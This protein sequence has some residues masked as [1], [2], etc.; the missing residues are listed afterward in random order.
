MCHQQD[1]YMRE[2]ERI[3]AAAELGPV[4]HDNP[5]L[6]PSFFAKALDG[7]LLDSFGDEWLRAACPEER[8]AE[9]QALRAL[10]ELD[11]RFRDPDSPFARY[12]EAMFE[13]ALALYTA[14]LRHGAAFE[15]LRR[16]VV[17][18]VTLCRACQG[19]GVDRTG[20]TCLGCE[21]AGTVARRR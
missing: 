11:P 3:A 10:W 5:L 4:I 15:N 13:L 8:A 19:V 20:E 2:I 12:Q 14:G 7:Q 17:G 16:T 18:E 21:G 1:D 6:D 9:R